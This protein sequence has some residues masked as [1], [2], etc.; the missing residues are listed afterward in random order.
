[1]KLDK[2]LTKEGIR[3]ADFAR[4]LRVSPGAVWQWCNGYQIAAEN[5]LPVERATNGKV[6]RHDLRPD[7]YPRDSAA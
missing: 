1:M 3:Q 2:Y 5:V 4:L 6:T 7:L